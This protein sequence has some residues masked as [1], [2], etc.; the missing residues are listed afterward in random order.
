[1]QP[2]FDSIFDFHFK[3]LSRYYILKTTETFFQNVV[4][5]LQNSFFER[6]YNK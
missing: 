3:S 4:I 5:I 1:M 2:F 6:N